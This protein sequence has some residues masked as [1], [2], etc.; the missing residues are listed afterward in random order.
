MRRA[1]Q[2]RL[3]MHVLGNVAAVKRGEAAAEALLAVQ[4][5]ASNPSGQYT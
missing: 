2:R 5:S 1:R 3:S 4:H